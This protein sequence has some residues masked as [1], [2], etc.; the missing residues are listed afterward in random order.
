MNR[1]DGGSR[2][3]ASRPRLSLPRLQ[4]QAATPDCARIHFDRAL[5]P[6]AQRLDLTLE[7]AGIF[8]LGTV[9]ALTPTMFV[10]AVELRDQVWYDVYACYRAG[11]G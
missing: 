10:E 4:R 2:K 5:N 6:T 8:I 3:R 11:L 1:D 9:Q 7:A